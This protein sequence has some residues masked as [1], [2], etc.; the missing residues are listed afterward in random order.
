ML[1]GD[2]LVANA[3][4][5]PVHLGAMADTVRCQVAPGTL[6]AGDVVVANNPAA[7][8]PTSPTSP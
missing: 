8:S 3:P 7:G 6:R 4:H 2:V 1:L 5:V